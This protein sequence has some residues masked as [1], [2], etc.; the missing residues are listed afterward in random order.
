MAEPLA[1]FITLSSYGDRVHGDERGSVDRRSNVLDEPPLGADPVREVRERRLLGSPPFKFDAAIRE[2]IEASFA[3]T[4]EYRGWTLIAI[5]CRTNHVHTVL[6]APEADTSEVL[7]RLKSRSTRAL[8]AAGI[9]GVSQPVWSRHGSTRYLWD[10]DDVA[11][12]VYYTLHFQGADLP[13]TTA[14]RE[15]RSTAT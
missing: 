14:A 7:H 12:A 5:H 2:A 13:G 6:A 11:A 8:R 10:E 9:V 15:H 4:C 3:E 1:Y